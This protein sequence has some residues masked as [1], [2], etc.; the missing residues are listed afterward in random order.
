MGEFWDEHYFAISLLTAAIFL[1][2]LIGGIFY[3]GCGT[4]INRINAYNEA[5]FKFE[6]QGYTILTGIIN[7][8]TVIETTDNYTY[9]TSKANNTMPIYKVGK[10]NVSY[11]AVFNATYGLAYYPQYETVGWW[12]WK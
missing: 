6:A 12:G 10:T 9:F 2:I 1:V 7:S 3:S 11:I 8:P 4:G 5:T